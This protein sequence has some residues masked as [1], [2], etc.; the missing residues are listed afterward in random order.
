[1]SRA[2][3]G[4]SSNPNFLVAP[5]NAIYNALR[6]FTYA[7]WLFPKSLGPTPN[8]WVFGRLDPT[9][10]TGSTKGPAFSNAAF[11]TQTF[12]AVMLNSA[13]ATLCDAA[14]AT[15][16]ATGAWSHVVFTYNADGDNLAHVY[17]NGV[18]SAYVFSSPGDGTV[19]DDSPFSFYVGSDTF[20]DNWDGYIAEL[21][22][23]NSVLSLSDIGKI[24]ASIN[25]YSGVAASNPILYWHLC[26]VA[27]PE[28]DSM[29][30]GI[31]LVLSPTPPIQGPDSPG[32]KCSN[33]ASVVSA[34]MQIQD[35]ITLSLQE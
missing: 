4:F 19:F 15:P 13:G 20:G 16:L 6:A 33:P 24:A 7:I 29:G 25:G 26:G 23:W 10:I 22:L 34:S 17:I 5:P 27:S 3:N 8:A 2:F 9:P 32:F 28:P 1:M 14:T 11:G 31:N 12:D 18:E 21:A 30:S 35:K